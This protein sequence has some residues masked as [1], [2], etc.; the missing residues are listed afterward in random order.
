M[1]FCNV[2]FLSDFNNSKKKRIKNVLAFY[3][4]ICTPANGDIV[5]DNSPRSYSHW[6]MEQF[7]EFLLRVP[8]NC[9]I[10]L[11]RSF[12]FIIDIKYFGGRFEFVDVSI[13]QCGISTDAVAGGLVTSV[14]YKIQQG[15]SVFT[16][17]FQSECGRSSAFGIPRVRIS[18][19]IPSPPEFLQPPIPQTSSEVSITLGHSR[20][21]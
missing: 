16:P 6:K 17:L 13:S 2:L 15:H 11:N 8:R 18:H 14:T 4:I 12:A 5:Y 3:L 19:L 1:Q 7:E 10:W 9:W 21:T 20:P